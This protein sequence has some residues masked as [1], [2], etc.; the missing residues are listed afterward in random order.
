MDVYVSQFIVYLLILV[1]VLSLVSTAPVFGHMSVPSMTKIGLAGFISFLLFPIVSKTTAVVDLRLV[2]LVVLVLK[3]AFVGIILGMA[4]GFIFAGIRYGG[5][6]IAFTMGLSMMN[7][8]DPESGQGSSVIGEFL[9]LFVILVFLT[10]NGHH[11]VLQAMQ[12]SYHSSPIGTMALSGPLYETLMALAVMI[13]VF[14]VKFAAPVMVATFLINVAFG[15]V[16]RVMPAMN[17]F[18]ISAPATIG[19]GF[20]ILMTLAPFI[21]FV[22]KKSLFMFEENINA[23]VMA[24]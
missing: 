1:R 2:P 12:L 18:F 3:E 16:S 10:I 5:E 22:F 8:F 20:L 11:Y 23:L 15:I 17:V 7:I 19:V 4:M 13:F 14:A 6:I 24:L 21:V 9:Y